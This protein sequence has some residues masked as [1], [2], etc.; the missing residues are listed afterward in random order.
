MDLCSILSCHP[1]PQSSLRN[2]N[3]LRVP[4]PFF[5]VFGIRR[6]MEERSDGLLSEGKAHSVGIRDLAKVWPVR[7]SECIYYVVDPRMLSRKRHHSVNTTGM[8][9]PQCNV[10]SRQV[11]LANNLGTPWTCTFSLL[12]ELSWTP[13]TC[14]FSQ[15]SKLS[16]LIV[17]GG[18]DWVVGLSDKAKF[19]SVNCAEEM[20]AL[21][22]L[23]DCPWASSC[24]CLVIAR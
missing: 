22:G 21:L 8:T 18:F 6:S 15:L 11:Q 3:G 1:H 16:L 4:A 7:D 12:S 24:C 14:T 10:S 19:V 13:W 23:T 5:K 20:S 9:G 17:E 2:T